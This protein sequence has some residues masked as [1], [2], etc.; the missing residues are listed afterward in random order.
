MRKLLTPNKH[1]VITPAK[2]KARIDRIEREHY[3]GKIDMRNM[4]RFDDRPDLVG[5]SG[6]QMYYID[7]IKNAE[8][9]Y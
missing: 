5:R 6:S 9:F 7:L 3:E 2:V 8:K 1:T 4:E